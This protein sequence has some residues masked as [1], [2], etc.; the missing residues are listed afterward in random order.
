MFL[1]C[2]YVGFILELY[3]IEP[4]NV[5]ALDKALFNSTGVETAADFHVG[6]P[7]LAS[8]FSVKVGFNKL[9]LTCCRECK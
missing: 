9:N 6:S 1:L 8:G 2:L 7:G 4:D 5:Q 3:S